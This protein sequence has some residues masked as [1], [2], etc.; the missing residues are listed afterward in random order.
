MTHKQLS[1]ITAFPVIHI[2]LISQSM[3]PTIFILGLDNFRYL[4]WNQTIP[5]L[6]NLLAVHET[7]FTETYNAI[8]VT[9]W[10]GLTREEGKD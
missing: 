3:S 9:L 4:H 2:D 5:P 10:M 6:K 8:L 7:T 1:I